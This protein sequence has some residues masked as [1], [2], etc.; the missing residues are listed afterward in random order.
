MQKAGMQ[1]EGIHRGYYQKNGAFEDVARYAILKGD[2][3]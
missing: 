2:R 1:F 3:A